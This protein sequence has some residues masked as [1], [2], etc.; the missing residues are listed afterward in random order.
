MDQTHG[1]CNVTSSDS[2]KIANCFLHSTEQADFHLNPTLFLTSI[3]C[4]NAL[5][6]SALLSKDLAN[7][8]RL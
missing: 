2:T 4:V 1:N 7:T 3:N 5:R 6:E 8:E